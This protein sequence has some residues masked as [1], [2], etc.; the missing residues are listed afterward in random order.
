MLKIKLTTEIINNLSSGDK[1]NILVADEK[2]RGLFVRVY[3]NGSKSFVIQK[4]VRKRRVFQ[5]LGPVGEL[6]LSQAR[7]QAET[8][9]ANAHI[10]RIILDEEK[11]MNQ[12]DNKD[13]I[14]LKE[15]YALWLADAQRRNEVKKST[16]NCF[17][18]LSGLHNVRV[19]DITA[20]KI[21]A[22]ETEKMSSGTK[23]ASINR[24]RTALKSLLVWGKENNI[25]S[26]KYVIPEMKR[27]S[28]YGSEK[29]RRG[30]T[31]EELKAFFEG[32]AKWEEENPQKG[33]LR[34]I[35]LFL[36]NTGFRPGS[37]CGLEWRD[38]DLHERKCYL[39]P[40][41]VKTRKGLTMALSAVAVEIIRALPQ[42]RPTEK[43]FT[44][45]SSEH[46]CK[47]IKEVFILAGMPE[48]TAYW[49]R[50]NYACSLYV[51]GATPTELMFQMGHKNFATTKRYIKP[52]IKHQLAV[53]DKVCFLPEGGEKMK[54]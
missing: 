27:L 40:E 39:R 8:L 22:W 20:E 21:L 3:Q 32:L 48:K 35:I 47:K 44:Q 13:A 52:D 4:F 26:Q 25:I 43:V 10:G 42:G 36:L 19:R 31:D 34:P 50:H 46:I 6:S 5:T 45:Y 9:I 14:R 29:E 24:M 33:Y 17:T 51:A 30:L 54:E 1:T 53:A 7:R 11:E 12:A 15:V 23:N 37:V 41:N 18:G 2:I 38:V 49:L 28:E 16:K